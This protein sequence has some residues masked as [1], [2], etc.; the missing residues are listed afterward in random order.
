MN[1]AAGQR[2]F[3]MGSGPTS[4]RDQVSMRNKSFSGEKAN[5]EGWMNQINDQVDQEYSEK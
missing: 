1:N 2:Q 4:Q 5:N 3:S